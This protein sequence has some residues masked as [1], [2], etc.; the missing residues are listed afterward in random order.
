MKE[1]NAYCKYCEVSVNGKIT[2]VTEL[3]S[4]NYLYIGECKICLYEVRRIV[5]NEKDLD[6]NQSGYGFDELKEFDDGYKGKSNRSNI[7]PFRGPNR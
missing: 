7:T 2:A 4:G 3:D 5:R 1:F 6:L